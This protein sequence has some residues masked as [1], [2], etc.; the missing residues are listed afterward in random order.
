MLLT[1]LLALSGAP[2]LAR[3]AEPVVLAFPPLSLTLSPAQFVPDPVS[4]QPVLSGNLSADPRAA[5]RPVIDPKDLS[6]EAGLLRALNRQGRASG[7][8]GVFYDNRDRGHSA[9][10]VLTFPQLTRLAYDPW[11]R[12]RGV[13]YGLAGL[14]RFG[15]IT[16]GNS[17][18]AVTEG[19]LWRSLP[20]LAMTGPGQPA[21]MAAD[22]AANAIYLYPEHHDHDAADLYPAAWPYMLVSQGSSGSDQPFLRA[23]GLILSA[24]RPDTRARLE[25]LGLVAPTV[26]M[27]FRRAQTGVN[28]SGDYMSGAAHPSAFD[29]LAIDAPAMVRLAASLAPDDIPPMV[30]LTVTSEDFSGANVKTGAEPQ[31]RSERLFDTQSAIARLWRS[32]AWQHTITVSAAGTKDPNGRPL[33]FTWVLLRGDP[34]HVTITPL[35]ATGTLARIRVDWQAP[36][37][38]P[39]GFTAALPGPLSSRVDIGVFASNGRADSAPAFVSITLPPEI[40]RYAAGPDGVPHLVEVDRDADRRKLPYDPALFQSAPWQESLR[41]DAYGTLIS[42]TRIT[43]SASPF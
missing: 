9:L 33:H 30:R 18:T 15:V 29:T 36:R 34:A 28:T 14:L 7:L 26:Q 40:R 6:P 13:D 38:A 43:A 10:P 25:S 5:A 1:L 4:R 11:L 41:Y 31:N 12:A 16:F 39:A 22:Y 35:D 2:G 32:D 3:P 21:R 37:P 17:S 8:V 27:V 20:R 42:R 19:P 23:V 24:F